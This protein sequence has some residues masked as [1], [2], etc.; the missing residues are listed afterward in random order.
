[1]VN[2][3]C[4]RSNRDS[5][6]AY[7]YLYCQHAQ[8]PALH[9]NDEQQLAL[10]AFKCN[11]SSSMQ[12]LLSRDCLFWSYRI[13]TIS[14]IV[15]VSEAAF[16]DNA[17]AVALAI[18]KSSWEG[19]SSMRQQ[20]EFPVTA[21]ADVEPLDRHGK[22]TFFVNLGQQDTRRLRST[23]PSPANL[24]PVCCYAVHLE[25]SWPQNSWLQDRA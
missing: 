12:F 7:M 15:P 14:S 13:S 6:P 8:I 17:L 16:C 20:H 10:N 24:G 3:H 11:I 25:P 21:F 9:T 4:Y 1:M 5:C 23:L 2:G 18:I 19:P 22:F